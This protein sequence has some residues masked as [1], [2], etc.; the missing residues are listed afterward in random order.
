MDCLLRGGNR[1]GVNVQTLGATLQ[2]GENG[3]HVHF[4]DP[5]GAAR[6]VELPASPQ[7]GDFYLI[8]NT[9]DALEVI[10]VKDSAGG[11]LTP[12]ITPTQSECAVV[13]YSGTA[14]R[15]FVALGA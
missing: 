12:A 11:A 13:V 15:G 10:T 8:F 14:W 1:L 3:P 7:K 4:L 9:A 6:D 5:G 2:I